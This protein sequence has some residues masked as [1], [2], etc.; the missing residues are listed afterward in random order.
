MEDLVVAWLGESLFSACAWRSRAIDDM[1][2]YD[3]DLGVALKRPCDGGQ[4]S[5]VETE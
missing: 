3:V 4:R 5:A 1:H 2:R